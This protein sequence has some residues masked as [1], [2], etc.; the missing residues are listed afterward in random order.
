MYE[1]LQF[2]ANDLIPRILIKYN[3]DSFATELADLEAVRGGK[4]TSWE[5]FFA[6]ATPTQLAQLKAIES[7]MFPKA[8]QLMSSLDGPEDITQFNYE[9][10]SGTGRLYATTTSKTLGIINTNVPPPPPPPRS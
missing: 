3:Q 4:G 2:V 5:Q 10:V 7:Q 6:N 1:L 8:L 9:E